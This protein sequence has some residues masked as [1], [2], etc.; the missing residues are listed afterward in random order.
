ME[1][2]SIV[3]IIIDALR[4]RNLSCYGYPKIV[5][6]N[7]DSLAKNGILFEDAYACSI[8]TDP[9][10]T[11]IFSGMRPTSHGIINHG[12]YVTEDE[13]R[14]LEESGV[15]F[16]PELLKLHG[17]R[18][19]A[20]DWFGRWHVRGYDHYTGGSK[21]ILNR[22]RQF[23]TRKKSYLKVIPK[24]VFKLLL[25][26]VPEKFDDARQVTDQAIDLLKNSRNERFF[27]F[28]HYWDTHSPYNVPTTKIENAK[29]DVTKDL[30]VLDQISSLKRKEYVKHLIES[31]GGI[32]QIEL[33]YE[34]ATRYVDNEIGRLLDAIKSERLWNKTVIIVTADH[35]ESLTEHGIFFDHHGLY[36]VCIHIPLILSYPELPARRI[37]GFVQHTDLVPTILELLSLDSSEFDGISL[38]PLIYGKK[39]KVHMRVFAEEAH[40]ERKFAVRNERYKFIHAFSKEAAECKYCGRIHGGI[41]ELYDLKND[42]NEI[43][44]IVNK[45]VKVANELR[46]ELIKWLEGG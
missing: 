3:F 44:N 6:P 46:E 16:L 24:S 38:L 22:I 23:T 31:A 33:R 18:T 8:S 27:L 25:R 29:A 1:K 37:G 14:F 43:R 20:V 19:M 7:L 32:K 21:Q 9:S 4:A 30:K 45:K 35:G 11:T 39:K 12:E 34:D 42:P 13:L 28:V 17:Y 36:D 41:E 2:P 15:Q 40:A 26:L 5:S 10:L